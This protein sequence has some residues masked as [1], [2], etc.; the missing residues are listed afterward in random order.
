MLDAFI[1]TRLMPRNDA[2]VKRAEDLTKEHGVK[3]VAYKVDGA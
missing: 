3:S 2:A 1:L